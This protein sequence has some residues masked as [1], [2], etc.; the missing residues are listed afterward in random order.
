M[1]W[2]LALLI[3]L[4]L[5]TKAMNRP[6]KFVYY[7]QTRIE[8]DWPHA[9]KAYLLLQEHLSNR[10]LWENNP[11]LEDEGLHTLDK[12]EDKLDKLEALKQKAISFA[13]HEAQATVAIPSEAPI[14]FEFDI[15]PR[16]I[17]QLLKE[18]L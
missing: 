3:I 11:D 18:R 12:L 10:H 7:S 8:R 14:D 13:T 6:K 17:D 16:I 5:N 2:F 4:S 15:T 1:N 9:K